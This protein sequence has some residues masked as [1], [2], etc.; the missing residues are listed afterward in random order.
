MGRAAGAERARHRLQGERGDSLERVE[1]GQ[2]EGVT[3]I[4]RAEEVEL[5]I[6]ENS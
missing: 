4:E 2:V 1:K 6:R 5:I 3:V